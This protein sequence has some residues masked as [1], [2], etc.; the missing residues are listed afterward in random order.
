MDLRDSLSA[1]R[2]PTLVISGRED[3]ATPPEHGRVIADGIPGARFEVIDD[4]TH[5]AN[6]QQPDLVSELIERH[7]TEQE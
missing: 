2:A 1:V 6:L 3:P 7:L 5:L 4:A